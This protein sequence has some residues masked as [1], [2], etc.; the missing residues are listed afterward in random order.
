MIAE[1]ILESEQ[2]MTLTMTERWLFVGMIVM[3]DDYGRF[4]VDEKVLKRKVFPEDRIGL[5]AI[6]S[7]V[8]HM[9][10]IGLIQRETKNASIGFHPNWNRYQTFRADRPRTSDFPDFLG[11]EGASIDNAGS[12]QVNG[13]KEKKNE[14]NSGFAESVLATMDNYPAMRDQ[15]ARGM[16][17]QHDR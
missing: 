14:A 3:A 2:V 7:A 13:S 8:E 15:L 11:D 9:C 10:A 6:G 5:Q 1:R 16:D 12:P 17:M 4:R